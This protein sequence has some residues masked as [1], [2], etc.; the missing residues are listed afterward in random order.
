MP[1]LSF[2]LPVRCPYPHSLTTILTT[3]SRLTP[4]KGSKEHRSSTSSQLDVLTTTQLHNKLVQLMD[5]DKYMRARLT[6]LQTRLNLLKSEVW[7]ASLFFQSF[8]H[9]HVI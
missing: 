2:E 1:K 4:P 5:D 7:N 8:I 9:R 3:Q 6:R